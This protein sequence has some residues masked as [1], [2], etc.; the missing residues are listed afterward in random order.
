MRNWNRLYG[1][2]GLF[3]HQS[4]MPPE[5]ASGVVE[6]LL[7]TARRSGQGSFL[8]V[9][10]RF[11]AVKSPGLLSFPRAGYT[12]TLDFP[13]RGEKTL[14]LLRLLDRI[15]IDAGGAVNPYKD[16]RMEANVFRASFPNWRQL[17]VCRDPAFMSDF[18]RRTAGSLRPNNENSMQAAE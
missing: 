3:Q 2:K 15:A 12:L 17:D 10:K 16:T 5:G 8:T 4:V 11:G 14:S 7:A 18:W 6:A 9:L 13:N 1:P